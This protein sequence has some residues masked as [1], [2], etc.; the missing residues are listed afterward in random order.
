MLKDYFEDILPPQASPSSVQKAKDA[1]EVNINDTEMSLH[2]EPA[3]TSDIPAPNSRSIRNITVSSRTPRRFLGADR[4]VPGV[5]PR[6]PRRIFSS[7]IWMW[8]IATLAVLILGAILTVALRPTT[9]YVVPRSHAI[10]FDSFLQFSAYPTANAP[11]DTLSYT[12]ETITLEDSAVVPS[13]GT[14][15]VEAKASGTIIVVNNYSSESVRLIPNTRFETSDGLI[16]RTSSQII[17]PGKTGNNPGE[18]RV[19]V[20]ADEAGEKYNIGPINRFT[21]PGLATTPAMYADVHARSLE[22]MT[23]GALGERPAVAAGALES[24]RAEIRMRLEQ[25]ARA[26][27]E[28]RT[29]EQ[30][31]ALADLMRTIYISQPNTAEAG[32]K[33]RIREMARVEIP[34]FSADSFARIVSRGVSADAEESTVMLKGIST[35]T[36]RMVET[37]EKFILGTDPFAF[38]LSGAAQVIWKVDTNSFA[39]ALANREAVAFEAIVATF[40]GIEEA[41]ARIQPFWKKTFPANPNDIQVRIEEPA[42]P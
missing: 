14:E 18:V 15:Y 31:V 30:T 35:L 29:N 16:F 41:H 28:L 6:P 34:V 36:S 3:R 13:T 17:I 25:Q 19:E 32:D 26:A 40:S 22:P 33:V 12:V 7:R 9:V 39:A 11:T 5:S 20:F 37:G 27:A 4:E 38:T 10:V 21:L 24:A 1:P 2:N 8:L 42:L 23:G